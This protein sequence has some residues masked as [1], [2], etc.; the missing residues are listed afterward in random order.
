MCPHFR[1]SHR[2]VT[3]LSLQRLWPSCSR[4]TLP[5]LLETS[6]SDTS[7]FSKALCQN[8]QTEVQTTKWLSWVL[9]WLRKDNPHFKTFYYIDVRDLAL[10]ALKAL[11]AFCHRYVIF[12]STAHCSTLTLR[13][14]IQQL[15]GTDVLSCAVSLKLKRFVPYLLNAFLLECTQ[16][17]FT[18][19]SSHFR[20]AGWFL[21][22][23]M[24]RFPK[25]SWQT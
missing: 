19:P 5:F 3:C 12:K 22:N 8:T 1:E 7:H 15:S 9:H 20:K 21:R 10:I 11:F 6:F 18:K 24:V 17:S 25:W 2:C 23:S 4:W 13:G 16:N 14:L